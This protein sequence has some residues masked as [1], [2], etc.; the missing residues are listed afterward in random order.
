MPLYP[1]QNLP[2]Y[3]LNILLILKIDLNLHFITNMTKDLPI[4]LKNYL[5]QVLGQ[6]PN[7]QDREIWFSISNNRWELLMLKYKAQPQDILV[8]PFLSLVSGF[9]I[10]YSFHLIAFVF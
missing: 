2:V 10:C 3:R 1:I 8:F 6:T 4:T 7:W 5:E 9:K